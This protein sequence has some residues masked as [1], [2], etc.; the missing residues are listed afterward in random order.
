VT[1]LSRIVAGLTI[2]AIGVLG[3]AGVYTESHRAPDQS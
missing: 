2:G 3:A 1:I